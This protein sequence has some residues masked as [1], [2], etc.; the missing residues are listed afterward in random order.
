MEGFLTTIRTDRQLEGR[1]LNYRR[2]GPT[3]FRR[4]RPA[5]VEGWKA[6]MTKTK[7]GF[8]GVVAAR[9][10]ASSWPAAR[11]S[12]PGRPRRSGRRT[13]GP[14]DVDDL[15][16]AVGAG[17]RPARARAKTTEKESWPSRSTKSR[18]ATTRIRCF[19]ISVRRPRRSTSW[20]AT[21]SGSAAA[22]PRLYLD[23]ADWLPTAADLKGLHPLA[24]KYLAEYPT[25][26][27]TCYVSST[28][29]VGA[30]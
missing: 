22:R 23:L 15:V 17:R 28:G 27:N 29:S 18:G 1:P 9:V 24:L 10:S 8:A 25:G 3:G 21:A 11:N 7:I 16:G 14:Q 30:C 19:S 13:G 4:E 6:G 26:S 12:R 2:A 20:S 5:R